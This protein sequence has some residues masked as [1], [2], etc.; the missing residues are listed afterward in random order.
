MESE[1]I[2]DNLPE[3]L[4]QLEEYIHMLFDGMKLWYDGV[5]FQLKKS[6]YRWALI[7]EVLKPL[8][9][10]LDMYDIPM[11]YGRGISKYRIGDQF[12]MDDRTDETLLFHSNPELSI[13]FYTGNYTAEEILKDPKNIVRNDFMRVPIPNSQIVIIS[14]SDIA[15]HKRLKPLS[16]QSLEDLDQWLESQLYME[17]KLN[18]SNLSTSSRYFNLAYSFQ[19]SYK[20]IQDTHVV[21]SNYRDRPEEIFIQWIVIDPRLSMQNPSMVGGRWHT[22]ATDFWGWCIEMRIR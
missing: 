20:E 8:S 11:S 15:W 14:K 13:S 5:N 7:P 21:F 4:N 22:F 19:Q 2:I 17:Y 10:Q 6:S 18:T 1:R 9:Q 16:E 3:F 12:I